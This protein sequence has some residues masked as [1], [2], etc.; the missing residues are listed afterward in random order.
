MVAGRHPLADVAGAH[1]QLEA[2]TVG[3]VI[4]EN[5]AG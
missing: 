5:G 3:K 4:V 1:E 2:G